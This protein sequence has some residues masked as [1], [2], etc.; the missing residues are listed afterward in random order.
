MQNMRDTDDVIKNITK[1]ISLPNSSIAFCLDDPNM[2]KSCQMSSLKQ[3]MTKCVNLEMKNLTRNILDQKASNLS[4]PISITA[5]IR[6]AMKNDLAFID[7]NQK[8]TFD[9]ILT[10][11]TM[12]VYPR[13]MAGLN[14]NPKK[15]ESD[16]QQNDVE[17]LLQRVC[18]K[19]YLRESGW[20]IIREQGHSRNQ[21]AKSTCEYEKG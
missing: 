19:T 9:T 11:L 10:T 3:Q 2:M 18:K 12:M 13:S 4:V 17:N 8:Y 15:E 5:L 14:L 7:E 21:P 16:F 6:F 1:I 20:E